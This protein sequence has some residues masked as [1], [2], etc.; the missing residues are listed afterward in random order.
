MEYERFFAGLAPRLDMARVLAREFDRNLA[1]RFNVLD[2]LRDDELGLSLIIADLLN[3]KA[4]HGQRSNEL[5]GLA[6]THHHCLALSAVEKGRMAE[7]QGLLFRGS[8]IRLRSST[9]RRTADATR[10]VDRPVLQQ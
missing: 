3:P 7:H 5:L 8:H 2:Y 1:H 10:P 6:A 4:S 9:R